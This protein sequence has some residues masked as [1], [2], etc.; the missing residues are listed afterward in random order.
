[1]EKIL[2]KVNKANVDLVMRL[3]WYIS[4]AE[5]KS[6]IMLHNSR[7]YKEAFTGIQRALQFYNMHEETYI[8]HN[9]KYDFMQAFKTDAQRETL[10]KDL[11]KLSFVLKGEMEL[12]Q[13]QKLF[14]NAIFNSENLDTDAIYDAL[15]SCNNAKSI[16]FNN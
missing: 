11:I 3:T 12:I 2:V 5:H 10:N 8:K 15:D 13:G 6:A 9:Q 1:M 16:A 7:R 4:K 14:E